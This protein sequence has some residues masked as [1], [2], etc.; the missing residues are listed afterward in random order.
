MV[1][2]KQRQQRVAGIMVVYFSCP[3]ASQLT[4]CRI[5]R[6]DP[7]RQPTSVIYVAVQGYK[8]PTDFAISAVRG[9]FCF[10]FL[11]L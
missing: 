7:R 5:S 11:L 10:L 6:A 2:R 3:C 1:E 9:I 8:Q 4:Q